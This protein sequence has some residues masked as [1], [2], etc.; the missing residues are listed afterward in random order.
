MGIVTN[1]HWPNGR[2]AFRERCG[3]CAE[4]DNG[5][6]PK[7]NIRCHWRD[8]PLGGVVDQAW[9]DW[10]YSKEREALMFDSSIRADHAAFIAGWS[11]AM[12]QSE[13]D[14][15]AAEISRQNQAARDASGNY[16][17]Y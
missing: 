8:Y 15:D 3:G 5:E 13:Q 12:Q 7:K 11:M 16:G 2:N 17:D 4:C 14:S 10:F 9:N 6:R 1:P